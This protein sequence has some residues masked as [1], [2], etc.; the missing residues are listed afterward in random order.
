MVMEFKKERTVIDIRGCGTLARFTDTENVIMLTV[1]FIKV[2][3]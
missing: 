1:T 2:N 3:G